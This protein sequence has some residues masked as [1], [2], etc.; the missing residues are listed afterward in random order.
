MKARRAARAL[1]MEVEKFP[2]DPE[3]LKTQVG[4]QKALSA[5]LTGNGSLNVHVRNDNATS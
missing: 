2:I 1:K 5:A 3:A 4:L